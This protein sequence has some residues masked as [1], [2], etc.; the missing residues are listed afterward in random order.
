MWGLSGLSSHRAMFT[1]VGM[2]MQVSRH[3][4]L[5]CVNAAVKPVNGFHD[6]GPQ[7]LDFGALRGHDCRCEATRASYLVQNTEERPLDYLY[8]DTCWCDRPAKWFSRQPKRML[9]AEHACDD[10]VEIRLFPLE[11]LT[12]RAA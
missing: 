9:C 8:T 11:L 4:G 7:S 12:G 2:G 3:A 6:R 10:A 5:R 1:T